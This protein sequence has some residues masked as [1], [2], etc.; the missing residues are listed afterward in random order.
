MLFGE[1]SQIPQ[2]LCCPGVEGTCT[3]D[4]SVQQLYPE[5]PSSVAFKELAR[6]AVWDYWRWK[7]AA[8]TARRWL[9]PMSRPQARAV[10]VPGAAREQECRA[11]R[12]LPSGAL[13]WQAK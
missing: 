10:G 9:E 2:L 11:G 8:V 5:T 13:G 6:A 3:S 4:K 1:G 7:D 12:Q